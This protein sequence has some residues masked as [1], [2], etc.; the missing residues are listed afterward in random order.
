MKKLTIG[1]NTYNSMPFILELLE[2]IKQDIEKNPIIL[3]HIDFYLYDDKSTDNTLEIV[4]R[5]HQ[6]LNIKIADKNNGGPAK[7]RNYIIDNSNS[8][9][10]LF[11]DGD[12]KFL[13]P[14]MDLVN[15]LTF[16]DADIVVSCPKFVNLSGTYVSRKVLYQKTLFNLDYDTIDKHAHKFVVHQMGLWNIFNVK[17]INDNNLRFKEDMRHEDSFFLTQYYMRNPRIGLINN[18]S[19]YGWRTNENGFTRSKKVVKQRVE[20]Y[21]R[22]L[23]EIKKV[24]YKNKYS[25]YLIYSLYNRSF[26]AMHRNFPVL[27]SQERKEYFQML[28]AVEQPHTSML[29]EIKQETKAVSR[30]FTYSRYEIFHKYYIYKLSYHSKKIKTKLKQMKD[31]IKQRIVSVL[32]INKNKIM[33]LNFNGTKFNDNGKYLYKQLKADP[34][35]ADHQIIVPVSKKSMIKNNDFIH[36]KDKLKFMYHLSTSAHVY[37][38]TWSVKL[39]KRK[40]QKWTLMWHGIP[41]KKVLSDIEVYNMTWSETTKERFNNFIEKV[42]EVYSLNSFNTEIFN[43]IFGK[44]KVV[45]KNYP[46]I[47]WLEDNVNNEQLKATI[48]N[49]YEL[50]AGKYV[51]YAPTYRPY[52]FDLDIKEVVKMISDE[53]KLLV[54]IHNRGQQIEVQGYEDKIIFLDDYDVQEIALIADSLI[55][56]YSSLAYD[57]IKMNKS[58]KYY[59][60]D[61]E[62]YSLLH[63]LYVDNLE[64]L[65]LEN[66]GD[67]N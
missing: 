2:G 62:M 63:G 7:G 50:F 28:K 12:D 31:K 8:Q 53:E 24:G 67:D 30:L 19:Y 39:P 17:F 1:I 23:E 57:F 64:F 18:F 37:N 26:Y 36:M 43:R 14:L 34:K 44:E 21:A 60:P 55:T 10:L 20:L 6:F 65:R 33:I 46:K 61:Y 35:Y 48:L 25:P 27:N 16:Q 22:M 38:N 47:Q 9:F 42:D 5:Y 32:P 45:E 3:E 58:V 11:I 66:K 56:D 40:G 49:K 29:A 52:E 54:S 15:F 51:L 13:C 41:H 4:N 59:Q